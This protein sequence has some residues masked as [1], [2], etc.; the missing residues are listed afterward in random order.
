MGCF[1]TPVA[2][3]PGL[4]HHRPVPP[5]PA[6]DRRILAALCA[7]PALVLCAGFAY[8]ALAYG[9]GHNF[10]ALTRVLHW[11][12]VVLAIA[13][14]PLALLPRVAPCVIAFAAS[15]AIWVGLMVWM[16]VIY[17]PSRAQVVAKEQRGRDEN[18]QVLAKA[19][20]TLA[21]SNGDTLALVCDTSAHTKRQRLILDVVPKDRSVRYTSL[22]FSDGQYRVPPRTQELDRH[23]PFGWPKCAGSGYASLDEVIAMMR[24]HHVAER[25]V[26]AKDFP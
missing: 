15:G 18:A 4:P 25:A 7:I 3:A 14:A 13:G 24:A 22:V 5:N 19:E 6:V 9:L 12:G 16:S 21:C 11:V 23:Y 10:N 20:A 2:P 26:L 1:S 17:T 8:S